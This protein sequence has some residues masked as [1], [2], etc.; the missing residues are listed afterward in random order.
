MKKLL[1]FILV[2]LL[3]LNNLNIVVAK[4]EDENEL[5]E[6]STEVLNEENNEET[7][8]EEIE[9][10]E[11]NLEE[12]I[13][14]ENIIEEN[15]EEGNN[16]LGDP[17]ANDTGNLNEGAAFVDN[18]PYY[19]N[20]EVQYPEIELTG[21][22][23]S[24]GRRFENLEYT[25]ETDM[26]SAGWHTV[27]AT[28]DIYNTLGR[29]VFSGS[30]D[31]EYEI[32]PAILSNDET[33]AEYDGSDH[34]YDIKND[35]NNDI[36][37]NYIDD[38]ATITV[39]K[40]GE[41][42]YEIID[43]GTYQVSVTLNEGITNYQIDEDSKNFEYTVDRAYVYL[44]W[45]EDVV[46][47]GQDQIA[48]I[49]PTITSSASGISNIRITKPGLEEPI[50]E[51]VN[52][53]AY[54]V[55]VSI[56]ENIA[57][58]ADGAV[59]SKIMNVFPKK[60]SIVW[61]EQSDVVWNGETHIDEFLPTLDGTLNEY[62]AYL[63]YTINDRSEYDYTDVISPGRYDIT[64]TINIFDDSLTKNYTFDSQ[65]ESRTYDIVKSELDVIWNTDNLYYGVQD[66]FYSSML[67]SIK[68][69]LGNDV[70]KNIYSVKIVKTYDPIEDKFMEQEVS[71]VDDVGTYEVSIELNDVE[72]YRFNM[73]A[74]LTHT[75]IVEPRTVY[76]QWEVLTQHTYNGQSQLE[77]LLPIVHTGNTILTPTIEADM[78]NPVVVS[79]TYMDGTSMSQE[80]MALAKRAGNYTIGV[81]L[82]DEYEGR[83]IIETCL[84]YPQTQNYRI[85]RAEI[86][87]DWSD[88]DKYR[89]PLTILNPTYSLTYDGE[90]HFGEF[91]PVVTGAYEDE[92]FKVHMYHGD[93]EITDVDGA[94]ATQVGTYTIN[95][96]LLNTNDYEEN[97]P[98]IGSVDRQRIVTI[99]QKAL[100]VDWSSVLNATTVYDGSNKID[101][102]IPS[103]N[104]LLDVDVDNVSITTTIYDE[105]GNETIEPIDAGTYT[106][107]A[108][109]NDGTGNYSITN[110]SLTHTIEKRIITVRNNLVE[111][112]IDKVYDPNGLEITEEDIA[113]YYDD[114]EQLCTLDCSYDNYEIVSI[115]NDIQ[116]IEPNENGKYVLGTGNYYVTVRL[117]EGTPV[118][119]NNKFV[120]DTD[121]AKLFVQ[122][123]AVRFD[124]WVDCSILYGRYPDTYVIEWKN[125]TTIYNGKELGSPLASFVDEDGNEVELFPYDYDVSAQEVI[126]DA[127]TYEVTVSSMYDSNYEITSYLEPQQL[128]VLPKEVAV[129]WTKL[130]I[131]S[132]ENVTPGYEIIGLVDEDADKVQLKLVYDG[133]L[134]VAPSD[135]GYHIAT[136]I[137][138][139]YIGEDTECKNY[140]LADGA[141]VS[142]SYVIVDGDI[143]KGEGEVSTGTIINTCELTGLSL[144][145]PTSNDMKEIIK[146]QG[147]SSLAAALKS[148][149]EGGREIVL[150]LKANDCDI[151]SIELPK[152]K[153]EDDVVGIDLNLFAVVAGDSTEYKITETGSYDIRTSVTLSKDQMDKIGYN[154]NKD[155]YVLRYHGEDKTTIKI[156]NPTVIDE[157]GYTFE[158]DS[159]KFSTYV[160]YTA[161]KPYNPTPSDDHK[162]SHEVPNT[163]SF[164]NS[165]ITNNDGL[166]LYFKKEEEDDE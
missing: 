84:L 20:S 49:T 136:I 58:F 51:V 151:E 97:K 150:Y 46:Y 142:T 66:D 50:T 59:T 70:D 9:N 40:G 147:T 53:G 6:E 11:E 48:S 110:S 43:P 131:S 63:L 33:Y 37:D 42:C 44:T 107:E 113:L 35:L 111:T 162:H 68:D 96:E 29:K 87:Y 104:G 22:V 143:Q 160:F 145:V 155:I 4:E 17:V 39:T 31:Y 140:T 112:D 23:I 32:L 2:C 1:T 7:L 52:A 149:L 103:L 122:R 86:S 99:K 141:K 166:I 119:K 65:T 95:V 93:I 25:S 129:K 36:C 132:Y 77:N 124:S 82:K 144:A 146:A 34:L 60:L 14:E 137:G 133:K 157:D 28:A 45:P 127:K 55:N 115:S 102:F 101:D 78:L 125:G 91:L 98:L 88:V 74:D 116:E 128:T 135:I 75:Y 73:S 123:K 62:D 57:Q 100:S 54:E 161:N 30:M 27:T 16:L 165:E 79:A 148:A 71:K 106:I 83:Y 15:Y 153:T 81:E 19:Y 89:D 121:V 159:N 108:E 8:S 38:V 163:E 64:A 118:A 138:F 5:V 117:V 76:I 152:G 47:N 164:G 156:G 94:T 21:G 130:S 114:G 134:E 139:N 120:S 72:H 3:S 56:D 41:P 12:A 80:D 85:N 67:P 10:Q 18:G 24:I 92:V 13:Q 26:I 158:F 126:K 109:I 154:S 105:E 61:N 90:N 69:S